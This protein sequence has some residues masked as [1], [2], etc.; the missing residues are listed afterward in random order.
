MHPIPLHVFIIVQGSVVQVRLCTVRKFDAVS[1]RRISG[2]VRANR[3]IGMPILLLL[4]VLGC[5]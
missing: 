5:S 3:T 4:L 1:R 2:R